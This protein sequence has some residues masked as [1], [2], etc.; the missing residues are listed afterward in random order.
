VELPVRQVALA[1]A[2]EQRQVR[3]RGRALGVE[4][5]DLSQLDGALRDLDL[6][7]RKRER[8]RG[9]GRREGGGAE[10]RQQL[11]RR[12]GVQGDLVGQVDSEPLLDADQQ[13]EAS[14]AVDA[15]AGRQRRV[16]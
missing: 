1:V 3:A 10:R 13:L 9:R 2:G 4:A 6:F 12:D 11:A 7:A 5:Q 16:E 8:E 14:E 15:E